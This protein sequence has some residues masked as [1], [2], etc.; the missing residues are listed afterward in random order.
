MKLTHEDIVKL[1]ER[2]LY[3]NLDKETR[4]KLNVILYD[5]QDRLTYNPTTRLLD[6]DIDSED[7]LDEH[8]YYY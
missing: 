1:R 3:S 4:Y 6:Y 7:I 8:Q 2:I 5:I